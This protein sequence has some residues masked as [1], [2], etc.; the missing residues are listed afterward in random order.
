M[1]KD[2]KFKIIIIGEGGVG[3]TSLIRSYIDKEFNENYKASIG[4]NLFL[5]KM[6]V[7]G[8][9]ISATIWDLA[10]QTRFEKIRFAYYKGANG[11]IAVGDLTQKSTFKRIEGFWL[12]DFKKNESKNVPIIILANKEDLKPEIDDD[13]LQEIAQ[14]TNSISVIKTS[15]KTGTHVNEA[16]SRLFEKVIELNLK[17]E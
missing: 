14:R 9:K 2:L 6:D 7:E 15:A 3:K 10:G 13:S 17:K 1:S 16:F 8:V 4:T 5:K 11:V 12:P